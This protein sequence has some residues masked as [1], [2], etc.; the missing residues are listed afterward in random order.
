MALKLIND[1]VPSINQEQP[2]AAVYSACTIFKEKT[3]NLDLAQISSY[4]L[5]YMSSNPVQTGIYATGAVL[6]FAPGVVTAPVLG[7]IGFTAEGVAAGELAP[8]K[9]VIQGS[10]T[11]VPQFRVCCRDYSINAW[12][13]CS[14]QR[15]CY[16]PERGSCGGGDA[17]C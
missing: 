10:K 11:K 5:N 1:L 14:K 13:Y 17:D 9:L 7:V 4:A 15:L 8:M 6:S 12:A 16:L 3:L 2:I